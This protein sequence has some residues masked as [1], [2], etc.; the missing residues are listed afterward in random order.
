MLTHFNHVT[1]VARDPEPREQRSASPECGAS[2]P[3]WWTRRVSAGLET[4]PSTRR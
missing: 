2:A 4:D 1:I 3:L